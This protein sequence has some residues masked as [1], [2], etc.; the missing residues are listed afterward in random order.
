M[1]GGHGTRIDPDWNGGGSG[2]L[3]G[4]TGRVEPRSGGTMSRGPA[5]DKYLKR[6]SSSRGLQPQRRSPPPPLC[7]APSPAFPPSLISPHSALPAPA[8]PRGYR[9]RLHSPLRTHI[10]SPLLPLS[11]SEPLKVRVYSPFRVRAALAHAPLASARH[12]RRW[13]HRCVHPAS[14]LP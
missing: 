12:R 13:L 10:P 4:W 7:T 9:T 14:P 2:R 3:G 11:M 8:T 6:V 1:S 5:I